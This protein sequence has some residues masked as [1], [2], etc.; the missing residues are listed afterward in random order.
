MKMPLCDDGND[1]SN[2]TEKW[3]GGVN[4]IDKNDQ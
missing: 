1:Q 4:A 2:Y 3:G